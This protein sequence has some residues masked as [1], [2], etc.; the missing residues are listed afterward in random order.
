MTL[1]KITTDNS[2]KYIP[3]NEQTR[4]RER[5]KERDIKPNMIKNKSLPKKQNKK[6]SQNK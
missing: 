4:E 6:L 1:G 3:Q 5:E 2:V